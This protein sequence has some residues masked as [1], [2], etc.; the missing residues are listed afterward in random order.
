MSIFGH[1]T[2]QLLLTDN[3]SVCLSFDRSRARSYA[4]LK[5]I[6]LFSSYC[7]ARNISCTVRW[8]PSELNNANEPS[9]IHS[10]KACENL[11]NAI[12]F[13]EPSKKGAIPSTPSTEKEVHSAE[14]QSQDPQEG[15]GP[16]LTQL[17]LHPEK[18][19]R[20]SRP[21]H[22]RAR[23][24]RQRA[25]GVRS[26]GDAS[27]AEQEAKGGRHN[28][29]FDKFHRERRQEE[30]EDRSAEG[31]AEAAK[32]DRDLQGIGVQRPFFSREPCGWESCEQA[33]YGGA[34]AFPHLWPS[35]WDGPFQC[36]GHGQ[37]VGGVHESDVF[38]RPPELP[39]RP[40][41]C[42]LST[43]PCGVWEERR[44][45]T[46]KMLESDKRISPPHSR[47]DEKK[48]WAV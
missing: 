1:D 13:V 18:G 42:G 9:R 31:E 35:S 34:S 2:R 28:I 7:L 10:S 23:Q 5:Q 48:P 29:R 16:K 14:E 3:M 21:D 6:R 41:P 38:R 39:C 11:F 45:E 20:V 26:W 8:I 37:A 33:V 36:E 15:E 44:H 47:E 25:S 17:K 24:R 27:V 4:L 12:P 19:A 46:A 40:S 43:S 32:Q 30:E 22:P